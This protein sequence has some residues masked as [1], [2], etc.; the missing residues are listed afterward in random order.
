MD[1]AIN[2]YRKEKIINLSFWHSL[3]KALYPQTCNIER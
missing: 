3:T 2:G 1:A